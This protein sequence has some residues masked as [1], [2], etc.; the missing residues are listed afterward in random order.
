[1]I[2]DFRYTLRLL[3]QKPSFTIL[4]VL[5][6]GIGI[7]ANAAIFSVVD[8]VLLRPLP[9]KDPEQ[10]VFIRT[11]LHGEVGHAGVAPAEIRDIRE[12]S[13][14]IEQ[15]GWM[16]TP[17]ASLTGDGPMEHV[18]AATA[19]DDFLPALG[20]QPTLGRGLS[21]KEDIGKDHVDNLLISYDLWDRR[22]RRDPNVI[23]HSIQ[24]NNY[25]AKIVGVLPQSFRLYMGSDT[26]APQKIDIWFPAEAEGNTRNYHYYQTV[27]RLRKGATVAR[28]QAEMEAIVAR[29]IQTH[30]QDYSD[31]DFKIRLIP[32]LQDVV[33]PVRTPLL[34]LLV[35]VGF[36]L[37]IACG[38][39]AN[40]LLARAS[41]RKKEIA[42]R[43]A[44]GAHRGRVVRQLLAES[45]TLAILGGAV[46]LV[47]ADQGI[48]FLLYLR[49]DHLPRLDNIAL[50]GIVTLFAVA[51]SL[52]SG[53]LFGL[54][55]SLHASRSD[56][57]SI[58]KE[59]ARSLTAD[60][61]GLRLRRS[62]VVAQVSLS[63]V[64]LIGAGLMIRTFENMR[65]LDLGFD[66]TNLLTFRVEANPWEF[67]G[68]EI[69]WHFYERA[70][71]AV[72]TQFGVEAVSGTGRLPLEGYDLPDLYALPES[73]DSLHNAVFSPVLPGYFTTMRQ[74][75]LKGREFTNN[76]NETATAVAIVD[77]QFAKRTWPDQDVMGKRIILRAQSKTGRR[78]AEIIGVVRRVQVSG[79]HVDERPQIYMPYRIDPTNVS[80]VIRTSGDPTRLADSLRKIIEGLGGKRP[81]WDLRLM[82]DYVGDAMAETRFALVLLGILSGISF[83]LCVVGVYGVVAYLVAERMQEFA[84]R[85]ALGAQP[86]DIFR[87]AL[88]AGVAP[89]VIGIG[90]G[91]AAALGLTPFLSRLLFE[92]SAMDMTTYATIAL[93]VLI[94]ALSACYLPVRR[95]SRTDPRAF[96]Q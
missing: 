61:T 25:S 65:R 68:D 18:T 10:L 88:G 55:P 63:V 35:A 12:Q 64:L 45:I 70:I 46:G 81:V 19:S 69:R 66:P 90:I 50:N 48:Q 60:A 27:A 71:D 96:L 32:L 86:R 75:L 58:L 16:V 76:D 51:I 3:W 95:C 57:N 4:S 49:P 80:M 42:I 7:G 84:I 36:V 24:V 21:G 83:I 38:N 23:G 94:A 41:G 89:A 29:M 59:S 14:S 74:P 6:I 1:M 82:T 5:V 52:A 28:A 72:K 73:P 15:I 56:L 93:L 92:V 13:K 91:I 39:V 22:Y 9:Y 87:L 20:I 54:V 33:K 85:M 34:V 44:L 79:F 37:L 26:N 67:R 2:Q 47:L 11:D 62:L 17:A 78:V 43:A 8:G 77:E 53:I 40:L 31:G 30:P